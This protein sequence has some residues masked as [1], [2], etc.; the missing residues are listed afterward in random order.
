MMISYAIYL[1]ISPL[2]AARNIWFPFIQNE[3]AKKT[4]TFFYYILPKTSEIDKLTSAL[5]LNQ[6]VANYQQLYSSF[7]FLTLMIGISIY[8][9]EKK[10]F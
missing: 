1:I 10:D 6:P 9:F 3:F 4:V 2:L 5:V 8:I 7:I